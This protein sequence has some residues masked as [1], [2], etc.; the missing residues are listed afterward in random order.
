[1][2]GTY[3]VRTVSPKLISHYIDE[4]DVVVRYLEELARLS[5]SHPWADYYRRRA[6][7]MEPFATTSELVGFSPFPEEAVLITRE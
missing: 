1:M 3:S 7:A 4:G 6:L 2:R 5:S